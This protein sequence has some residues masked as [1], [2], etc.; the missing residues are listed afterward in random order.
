MQELLS[1]QIVPFYLSGYMS[2]YSLDIDLSLSLMFKDRFKAPV[3]Y[4]LSQCLPRSS[5]CSIT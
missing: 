2:A 5:S 4:L 3:Q 1:H